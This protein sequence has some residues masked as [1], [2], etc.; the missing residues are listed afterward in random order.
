[1]LDCLQQIS[2]RY[3]ALNIQLPETAT[4]GHNDRN[5]IDDIDIDEDEQEDLEGFEDSEAELEDLQE[6]EDEVSERDLDE[7]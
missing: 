1:M 4:E 3:P 6:F 5:D 2:D 7:L